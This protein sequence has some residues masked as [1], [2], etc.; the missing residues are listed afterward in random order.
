[1][2]KI[3]VLQGIGKYRSIFLDPRLSD[4]VV[5]VSDLKKMFG[6][7]IQGIDG[8]GVSINR[9]ALKAVYSVLEPILISKMDAGATIILDTDNYKKASMLNL[10]DLSEKFGYQLYSVNTVGENDLESYLNHNRTLPLEQR[11]STSLL[12]EEFQSFRNRYVPQGSEI[13]LSEILPLLENEP[14]DLSGQKVVFVGDIQSCSRQLNEL[15]D[16]EGRDAHYVFCGDV[17]DRGPDSAGVYHSL[18]RLVPNSHFVMGNHDEHLYRV[19]N[20]L[21][22]GRYKQTLDSVAQLEKDGISRKSILKFVSRFRPLLDVRYGSKRYL[23]THGGVDVNNLNFS[24]SG[25][26]LSGLHADVEFIQGARHEREI[27]RSVG[28]YPNNIDSLLSNSKNGTKIFDAQFH[29]HRNH[30]GVPTLA[31]DGIYNLESSVEFDGFLSAVVLEP[32]AEE[33]RIVHVS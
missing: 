26:I 7:R 17:F 8:Y 27:N 28:D 1:M 10:V 3:F 11:D 13:S 16:T 4:L 23:V 15:V 18:Q 29:G 22:P 19:F 9:N 32:E 31:A 24:E 5:S 33:P 21:F 2:R 6:I 14:V 30:G 20:G 12:S 25:N